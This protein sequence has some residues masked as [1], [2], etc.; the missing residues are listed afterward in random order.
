MKTINEKTTIYLDPKV[1]K[2][3]QHY[4]LREGSSL[5]SIVNDKL[6]DY[7]EDMAD[8][9]ALDKVKNSDEDYLPFEEVV[10]ELGLNLDEIRRK[11]KHERKKTT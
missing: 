11:A 5:S 9:V 1:K 2:S 8:R 6:I 4:A 10:E 3:V 7:L